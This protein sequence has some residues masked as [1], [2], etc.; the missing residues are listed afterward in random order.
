MAD[1]V[2]T[3]R[4]VEVTP[5]IARHPLATQT[6]L[7]IFIEVLAAGQVWSD[8]TKPQRALIE[9]LCEPLIPRLLAQG[10]LTEAD[11]PFVPH[12]LTPVHMRTAMYRRG[13]ISERT[14][15]LT[16]RAVHA[17]YW[18]V[19]R[20]TNPVPRIVDVQRVVDVQLPE[21]T[22]GETS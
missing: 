16:A 22:T 15:R 20:E 6:G 4:P 8:A 2:L 3:V 12:N 10:C 11:Q 5:E 1:P 14:G 21:P 13:L 19:W 7:S 17:Y 18:Q 9:S